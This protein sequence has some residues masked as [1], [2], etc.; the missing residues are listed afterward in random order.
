MNAFMASLMPN[1]ELNSVDA[2]KLSPKIDS[3]LMENSQIYLLKLRQE[4]IYCLQEILLGDT[5][6]A[7]YLL[8]HLLSSV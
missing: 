2:V 7:E 5:L 4:L 1:N 6:A 3:S 8:M